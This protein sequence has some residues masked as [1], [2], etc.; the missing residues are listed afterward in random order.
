MNRKIPAV[1]AAAVTVAGCVTLALAMGASH[2]KG[3]PVGG[4]NGWPAGLKE[5][6]NI[7]ARTGG[8]FVNSDDVFYFCG[9]A[10]AFTK[11][12]EQYA[13]LQDTPLRLILHPGRGMSATPWNDP[14]PEPID[15]SLATGNRAWRQIGETGKKPTQTSF[16]VT[17][18]LYLGGNID[19]KDLEVPLEIEVQSSGEIEK[20]II[21]HDAQR[22]LVKERTEKE[23]ATEKVK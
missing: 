8:F 22:Q 7:D 21:T 13:K 4:T 18:H 1:L 3:Q 6:V 20:F 15:W 10:K 5:L 19:L 14:K 11:F 23:K 9:D 16:D 17:V 2:P 12:L